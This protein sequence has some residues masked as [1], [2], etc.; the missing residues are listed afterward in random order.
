VPLL[1]R[2]TGAKRSDS[3]T[4]RSVMFIWPYVATAMGIDPPPA[5]EGRSYWWS[6][7]GDADGKGR[8]QNRSAAAYR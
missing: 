8:F 7:H 1:M 6:T 3:G 5:F 2:G 4:L